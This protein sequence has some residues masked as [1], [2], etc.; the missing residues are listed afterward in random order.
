[1]ASAESSIPRVP[2]DARVLR[3]E[4]DNLLFVGS[5]RRIATAVRLWFSR[6]VTG[7]FRIGYASAY[8]VETICSVRDCRYVEIPTL[9]EQTRLWVSCDDGPHV[10]HQGWVQLVQRV[11]PDKR[12][13]Y[14][15]EVDP[16]L[17]S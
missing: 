12:C 7:K 3:S 15:I 2:N 5:P 11:E 6:P 17:P 4:G 10:F 1:M 8:S 13:V 9:W 16:V 14:E